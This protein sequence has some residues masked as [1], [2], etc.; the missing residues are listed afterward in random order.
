M[1]Q[2][3]ALPKR[4]EIAA[5]SVGGPSLPVREIDELKANVEV[6]S[7]IRSF[8]SEVLDAYDN[9]YYYV[10]PRG[11]DDASAQWHV[12]CHLAC[13]LEEAERAIEQLGEL[14]VHYKRTMTLLDAGMK[15]AALGDIADGLTVLC[16]LYGNRGDPEIVA[17]AGVDLIA[18]EHASQ[19]ALY[20]AVIALCRPG[21]VTEQSPRKFMPTMPEIIEELRGNSDGG[22]GSKRA[23]RTCPSASSKPD[24]KRKSV[25]L[26]SGS[27]K[28]LATLA[29]TPTER[30]T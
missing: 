5:P 4:N 22:G 19:I 18:A 6:L 3:A 16:G 20:G 29:A 24:R 1:K 13:R 10:A 15:E 23:Y 7:K 28:K 8:A 12:R 25:S 26:K 11:R 14:P 9:P 2:I 21:G 30:L 17:G 27:A